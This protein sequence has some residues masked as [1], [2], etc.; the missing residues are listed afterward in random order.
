MLSHFA[1]VAPPRRLALCK[2]PAKGGFRL[3]SVRPLPLDCSFCMA[4]ICRRA[5]GRFRRWSSDWIARAG[6]RG[7]L[8][9]T[10]EYQIE[11]FDPRKQA[12]GLGSW[13]IRRANPADRS[14]PLLRELRW[15][16][17]RCDVGLVAMMAVGK[18]GRPRCA[19]TMNALA[20]LC[21]PLPWIF[22][23]VRSW[24]VGDI[25]LSTWCSEISTRDAA[26]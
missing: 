24:Q 16:E 3:T 19:A 18:A 2:Y 13:G 11:S 21:L 12:S 1:R 7:R 23:L 6:G 8:G 15:G 25:L 17:V 26:S 9:R 4:D 10:E 5:R 20:C 14:R 22:S